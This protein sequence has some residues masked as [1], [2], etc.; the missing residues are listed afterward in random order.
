MLFIDKHMDVYVNHQLEDNADMA[1]NAIATAPSIKM[2]LRKTP[3]DEAL[4]ADTV[5]GISKQLKP[6]SLFWTKSKT[7]FL[8]IIRL[9]NP[10]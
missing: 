1:A 7:L 3:V 6:V 9:M 2:A 5:K 8:F 10:Y 4:I